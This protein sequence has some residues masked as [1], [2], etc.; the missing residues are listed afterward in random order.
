MSPDSAT[1][2]AEW[3]EL[4]R[5]YDR[6]EADITVG[7]LR[8]HGVPVQTSGGANTALPMMGLSDVRILVPRADVERGAQALSAMNRG[9]A[10]A[11]PFRDAPPE[12]YESPV[13]QRKA[14]FATMLALLV[15]IGGGHFYARHGA[16]GTVLAGGIVGGFLGAYLGASALL[17]VLD[18]LLSPLAVRRMNGDAVPGDGAQRSWAFAGVVAAYLFA[19]LVAK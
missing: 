10:D 18:A 15:P 7:F 11:H 3:V 14:L 12:P 1:N 9:Q 16:A 19:L 4:L 13:V 5:V 6:F 17:V 2:D 8:D